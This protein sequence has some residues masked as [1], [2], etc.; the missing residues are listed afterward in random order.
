MKGED[1]ERMVITL[2]TALGYPDLRSSY[3]RGD[4]LSAADPVWLTKVAANIQQRSTRDSFDWQRVPS[5]SIIDWVYGIDAIIDPNE[6]GVR[7]GFDVTTDPAK[8]L[9]KVNRLIE[10]PTWK[11]LGLS[12]VAVLLVI[13]GRV[14][15]EGMS[16]KE[17]RLVAE[18][19][20][21]VVFS[22]SDLKKAV[23]SQVLS[24]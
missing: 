20:L 21:D 16:A 10:R 13:P 18:R 24:L 2:L 8:V 19:L 1:A 17:R 7:Y 15:Y 11:T 4:L 3:K 9:G 12:K 14:P 5:Q 6:D 23:S 22:M